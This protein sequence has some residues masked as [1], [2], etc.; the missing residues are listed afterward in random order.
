MVVVYGV[1]NAG[2]VELE[3]DLVNGDLLLASKVLQ[4]GRE[5]GLREEEA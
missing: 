1:L 5:E 4:N 2:K 3:V